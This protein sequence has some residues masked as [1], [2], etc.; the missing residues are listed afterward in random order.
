MIVPAL[1]VEAIDAKYKPAQR[2]AEVIYFNVSSS[3]DISPRFRASHAKAVKG[4]TRP[5]P[6]T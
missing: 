5:Y 2:L 4:M 6:N 1:L 3:S